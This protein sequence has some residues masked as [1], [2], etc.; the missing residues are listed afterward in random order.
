MNGFAVRAREFLTHQFAAELPAGAFATLALRV[1][2]A[3]L[4]F[5][6]LLLLARLLGAAAFGTYA[7]AIACANVLGVPAAAGF[8][9]LL[10]REVAALRAGRRWSAL[11]GLMRRATQVALGSSTLLALTVAAVAR[12]AVHDA[13]LQP[14][15]MLAALL[16][17]LVAFARLRQAAVQGLGHVPTGLFPETT[18]QPVL[19]LLLAS[20][21]FI[22]MDVPRTGANAVALQCVAAMVAMLVGVWLL[23]AL[24]PAEA[25]RTEP[26]YETSRWFTSATPLMIMLGMN[27]L[28]INADTIMMGWLID[29]ELAGQYRVAVQISALVGFPMTA[30]N[31]AVAP[32]L[33]RDFA[34]GDMATLCRNTLRASRWAL[35]S[36]L[37]VTLVLLAGGRIL[38]GLFGAE[39]VGVYPALVVLAMGWLVN[40][41]AGATGYLL[42]MTKH[43]WLA[44]SIFTI[45]ALANVM[46]NY[47]LIPKY[48]ASGAACATAGS[49]AL[50][51]FGFW[52]CARR[53]FFRPFA[54]EVE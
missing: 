52:T 18:V 48:G 50:L 13:R 45:A 6:G 11:R 16:L 7:I 14:A 41:L 20:L 43:E 1:S 24:W 54:G 19:M 42:I 44:A 3:A 53:L 8:D 4:E 5:L 29:E 37:P 36:A 17:P 31:M 33:A 40:S 25:T 39:F 9:R 49:L 30:I 32:N 2:H 28:L 34:L 51:G 12:W 27:M 38:L 23:R 47:L 21:A 15:L 22:A 26:S 10:I 35:L 46:A